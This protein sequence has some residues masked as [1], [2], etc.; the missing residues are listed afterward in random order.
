M[1]KLL[2]SLIVA[3]MLI[4]V[5]NPANS[6]VYYKVKSKVIGYGN[7]T[8]NLTVKYACITKNKTVRYFNTTKGWTIRYGGVATG[9]TVKHTVKAKDCVVCYVSSEEFYD[10]LYLAADGF[11]FGFIF[12]D[13]R[14]K[15]IIKRHPISG[16]IVR[17]SSKV[18]AVVIVTVAARQTIYYLIR[19]FAGGGVYTCSSNGV[20]NYVGQTNNF[21]RRAAEWAKEG[22][23]ITPVF[24]SPFLC[25]R[26][27]V[28]ETLIN[29]YGITN[30]INKIHSISP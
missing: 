1:K 27:V 20:V 21:T 15:D 6:S 18:V 7:T 29:R 8:K 11:T 22:R 10:M 14:C 25:E 2:M 26:R 28:E 17:I 24:R 3:G 4:G 13:E 9:W 5:P 30:L 23:I 19:H 16:R 12:D